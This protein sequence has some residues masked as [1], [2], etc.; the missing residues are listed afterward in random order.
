VLQSLKL[1]L[2][3][4]LHFMKHLPTF[5]VFTLER[6]VKLQM[7]E[8]LMLTT[9]KRPP[10]VEDLHHHSPEQLA[11]L[12]LL[13]ARNA[14]ARADLR[15]PGF[16]EVEGLSEVYYIFKYPTGAKILLLAVWERDRVAELAA[17]A[18]TAA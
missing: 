7:A 15:R 9:H 13:L 1:S 4:A 5:Y 6:Q 17:L 16:F 11:E 14:P 18:C 3:T 12:R 2:S 10:V 8:I